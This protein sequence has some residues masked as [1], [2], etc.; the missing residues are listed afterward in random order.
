MHKA[1]PDL[2]FIKNLRRALFL[3]CIA[4]AQKQSPIEAVEPVG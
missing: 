2:L 1:P 3:R 4:L